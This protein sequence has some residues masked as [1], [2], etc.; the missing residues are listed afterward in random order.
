VL[1]PG[2]MGTTEA[3]FILGN[4]LLGHPFEVH[5][6]SVEYP[7][8]ELAACLQ[9]IYQSAARLIGEGPP[10]LDPAH[11]HYHMEYLGGGYARPTQQS[12][13]AILAFART[14]GILLEHIYSAKTLACFLD[15]ARGRTLSAVSAAE[16]LCA[17]HTGGLPALFTQFETF[18][19]IGPL[20]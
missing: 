16:P 2:S 17:I 9:D 18:R 6:V 12:E 5:L 8:P 14:E 4:A 19:S 20:E 13:Q 7:L 11:V 1:L 3:G 15:L 10:A